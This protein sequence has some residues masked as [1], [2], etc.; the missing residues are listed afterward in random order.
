MAFSLLQK[1][2]F[3]GLHLFLNFVITV[4][5]FIFAVAFVGFLF[6]SSAGRLFATVLTL[7]VLLLSFANIL[8]SVKRKL[9][10]YVRKAAEFGGRDVMLAAFEKIDSLG[11]WEVE[12][13]KRRRRLIARLW[14]IPSITERIEF[15]RN[16]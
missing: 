1:K 9:L 6:G 13:A 14:P 10:V 15:L 3:I 8:R 5:A 16:L 2:G 4:V 12:K 7:P 11:I